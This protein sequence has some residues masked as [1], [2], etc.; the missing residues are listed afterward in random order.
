MQWNEDEIRIIYRTYYKDVYRFIMS[1]TRSQED[2]EDLTQEVFIRL[3][4]TSS[5][6]KGDAS[7]KTWLFTIAKNISMDHFRKQSRQ[8]QLK[9]FLSHIIPFKDKSTE[10]KI[11]KKDELGQVYEK[12]NELKHGYRMVIVLRNMQGFS[13]KETA[14]VMNWTESKVKVT[15]HRALKQLRTLLEDYEQDIKSGGGLFESE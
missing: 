8:L 13:V 3:F 10:E 7:M 11:E 5:K 14:S 15:Y 2:A 4:N 12:L 1:F 9:D 6:Y